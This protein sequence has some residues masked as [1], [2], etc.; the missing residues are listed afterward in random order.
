VVG[1]DPQ[2]GAAAKSEIPELE[3]ALDPYEAARG[4]HCVVLCTEWDEFGAL[5]WG[6][7]KELMAYP[8]VVD[9]RNY[10]DS[11]A[12]GELGFSYYPMGRPA[13]V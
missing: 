1:Y 11:A 6:R 8:V 13:I 9:G 5:D 12:L 2:A 7:I 4:A 10:L 3:I